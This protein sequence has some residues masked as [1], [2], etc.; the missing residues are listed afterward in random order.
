LQFIKDLKR[1][2]Q[3]FEMSDEILSDTHSKLCSQRVESFNKLKAQQPMGVLDK[4][5]GE[6]K[7]YFVWAGGNKK[8]EADSSEPGTIL[9][10]KCFNCLLLKSVNYYVY[11]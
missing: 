7:N 2:H 5:T 4:S 6:F 3:E 9:L 1:N 10:I 8:E 11:Y